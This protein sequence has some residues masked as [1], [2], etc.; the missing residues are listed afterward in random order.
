MLPDDL[1]PHFVAF[2]QP[3]ED[4]DEWKLVKSADRISAYLKCIEEEKMGNRDFAQ[5]KATILKSIESNDL[6]EVQDFMREFVP[7]FSLSPDELS[8]P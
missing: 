5:A 1:R 6:P 2:V 3:N 4:T 7:S 8:K